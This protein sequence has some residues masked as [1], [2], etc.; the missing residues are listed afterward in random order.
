MPLTFAQAYAIV[1]PD[2][3]AVAPHS[4]EFSDI[5][6]LM[7]QSGHVNFQ[8]RLLVEN[9]PKPVTTIAQATRFV[10][11]P[12]KTETLYISKREWLS[13]AANKELFLNALNKSRG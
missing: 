12:L 5:Q 4:K 3:G 10:E 13:V 9:V 6:E 1:C 11:R 7:R 2:G 8:D